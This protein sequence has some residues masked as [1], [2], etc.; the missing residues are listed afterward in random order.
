MFTM[1][2]YYSTHCAKPSSNNYYF[3]PSKH[4]S[5]FKTLMLTKT[6]IGLNE[7]QADTVFSLSSE[8]QFQ[9]FTVKTEIHYT[10]EIHYRWWVNM[11]YAVEVNQ[12]VNIFLFFI[13]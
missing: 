3:T 9:T 1:F 10:H 8:L 12:L 6:Y 11:I 13:C 4:I 5:W 2:I 7:K